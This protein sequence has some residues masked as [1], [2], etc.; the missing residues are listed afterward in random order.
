MN[1]KY[2][3]KIHDDGVHATFVSKGQKFQTI[4]YTAGG[5]PYVKRH[6]VRYR[7]EDFETRLGDEK[8][9]CFQTFS[10]CVTLELDPNGE[11]AK[12]GYEYVGTSTKYL[13]EIHEYYNS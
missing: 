8:A 3:E 5:I 6:G 7:L 1:K 10:S 12:V 2:F 9:Y 13:K 11:Y 4:K